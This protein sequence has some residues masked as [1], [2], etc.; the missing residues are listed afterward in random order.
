MRG[1][2]F[3]FNVRGCFDF[4]G[5]KV[6]LCVPRWRPS[7]SS[8]RFGESGMEWGWLRASCAASR[9]HGCARGARFPSN[10]SEAQD[11]ADWTQQNRRSARLVEFSYFTERKKKSRPRTVRALTHTPHP[12]WGS[13]ETINHNK[14]ED[15]NSALKREGRDA[16]LVWLSAAG[17]VSLVRGASAAMLLGGDGSWFVSGGGG[18]DASCSCNAPVP[19]PSYFPCKNWWWWSCCLPQ[20]SAPPDPLRPGFSPSER[21]IIDDCRGLPFFLFISPN[22]SGGKTS[23]IIGKSCTCA[24]PSPSARNHA[25]KSTDRRLGEEEEGEEEGDAAPS[26][27]KYQQMSPGSDFGEA[28]LRC[29]LR[30]TWTQRW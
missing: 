8:V 4:I 23:I 5:L 29:R 1:H 24:S 13:T 3:A 6:R 20:W 12:P 22:C 26:I 11:A 30:V 25:Q 10:W 17:P 15:R 7:I 14:R 18:E 2:F 21:W 16:G 27:T 28:P 19:P 9:V